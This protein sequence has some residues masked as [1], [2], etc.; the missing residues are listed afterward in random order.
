MSTL[1]IDQLT[2]EL[3]ALQALRAECYMDR[4]TAA[5]L[6]WTT[7][8]LYE[9][10]HANVAGVT[11][12]RA[13]GQLCCCDDIGGRLHISA[14]RQ[15]LATRDYEHSWVGT[16]RTLNYYAREM[17]YADGGTMVPHPRGCPAF[18]LPTDPAGCDASYDAQKLGSYGVQYW[19]SVAWATGAI[20][21]GIGCAPAPYAERYAESNVESATSPRTRFVAK[22]PPV[23]SLLTP[24][25]T[26]AKR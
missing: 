3:L 2:D 13:P 7:R 21:I 1:P 8:G 19:L 12:K 22:V 15:D 16:A 10:M 23:V 17:R 14:S 25:G 26:C 18:P 24:Y 20:D 11:I 6:P 4:G 9:W 5:V